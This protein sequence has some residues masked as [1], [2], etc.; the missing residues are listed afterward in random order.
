MGVYNSLGTEDLSIHDERAISLSPLEKSWL[1]LGPTP[2][3]G[4]SIIPA[5]EIAMTAWPLNTWRCV[6]RAELS[7]AEGATTASTYFAQEHA[8]EHRLALFRIGQ[9]LSTY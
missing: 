8:L 5:H 1:S 9:S 3:G 6:V 2:H 7:N 4:I